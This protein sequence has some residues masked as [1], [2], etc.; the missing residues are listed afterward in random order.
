[1]LQGMTSASPPDLRM[2]S[3]TASQASALRLEITTLAPSRASNSAEERP[4]PRLEPVT[5]ATLPV[6]SNG[7]F[8]IFASLKLLFVIPGRDEVASPESILPATAFDNELQHGGYGFRARADARP[9]MTGTR[10][11]LHQPAAVGDAAQVVVGVAEGVLDHSQPLEVVADFGL[12]GHAD[13]AME[14]K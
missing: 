7:V 8:F 3:A 9:G 1:M 11:P 14:A 2:P 4:M 10:G 13:A 5:T 12:H 6:R